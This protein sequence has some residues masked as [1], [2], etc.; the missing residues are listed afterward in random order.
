M[1]MKKYGMIICAA[2]LLL[3]GCGG[4]STAESSTPAASQQQENAA[5]DAG[6]AAAESSEQASD[7]SETEESVPGSLEHDWNGIK[8]TLPE[9]YRPVDYAGETVVES[10]AEPKVYYGSAFRINYDP[11]ND[12]RPADY[13]YKD[14]PDIMWNKMN[15][16]IDC[17]IP[18]RDRTTEKTVTETKEV[19]FLGFPAIREQGV[20][21]TKAND[22]SHT[23]QYTAYYGLFDVPG[24]HVGTPTV[25]LAFTEAGDADA[26]AA[27]ADS[28]FASGVKTN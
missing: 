2:A 20:L 8:V 13:T 11:A 19:D 15:Q 24:V 9:G 12:D 14:T 18:S 5:A 25:F 1:I 16:V 26:A 23:L 6:Q 10:V 22:E 28:V 4:T 3:S 7:S 21:V 17:V 27:L